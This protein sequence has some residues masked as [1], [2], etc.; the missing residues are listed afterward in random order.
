MD[1]LMKSLFQTG[2]CLWVLERSSGYC[3]T[4]WL[5]I[6]EVQQNL[7]YLLIYCTSR[8]AIFVVHYAK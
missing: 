8:G 3:C 5:K 4:Q 1:V 6:Q 2:L 7:T